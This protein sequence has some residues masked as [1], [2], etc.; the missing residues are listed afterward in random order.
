MRVGIDAGPLLGHGGISSYLCPL[1][2]ALIPLDPTTDYRLVV[3]RSWL[4]D[5]AIGRLAALGPVIRVAIPDRLLS[6]WWNHVGRPL[7]LPRGVWESFDVFLAT[8]LLAPILPAGRVVSI[9][10]DCIPLRLPELFPDRQAFR[11][12]LARLL[13]RSATLL[14]ISECTKRDMVELFGVNPERVEVLY[15]GLRP[16]FRPV[17]PVVAAAVAARYGIERPFVLYVGALGPH[18]NVPTLLRAFERARL[19]G[20]LEARLVL[21]GSARWGKET[22]AAV[23]RLRV[24]GDVVL[25]GR[26]P[27]EDL[28]ALYAAADLFV[29]PSR[30]EGF[31][32]PVLE[33]MACGTPVLT[34]RAGALPEVAG[35]AGSYVDPDDDRG[36]ADRMCELVADGDRQAAFRAAGLAQAARFSATRSATRLARLLGE[37]GEAAGVLAATSREST[38]S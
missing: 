17:A 34:S 6:L 2:E 16:G 27:D 29:F 15:P 31:G 3:R 26:V 24:R 22:L 38:R 13:D 20:G 25:T 10:Y 36:L 14:A 23:E 21:A 1:V 32:L 4:A 11:D 28:P 33:A 5:P 37:P 8:C 12:R 18:K 7:P 30:Y 19:A 9:V 35:A